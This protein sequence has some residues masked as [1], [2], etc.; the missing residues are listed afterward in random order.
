MSSSEMRK[1]A[2]RVKTLFERLQGA[3]T[4]NQNQYL[5]MKNFSQLEQASSWATLTTTTTTK[6]NSFWA[7]TF[8]HTQQ[9]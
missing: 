1:R 2:I 8:P 7:S 4:Q 3:Q 5:Q 6:L 9:G